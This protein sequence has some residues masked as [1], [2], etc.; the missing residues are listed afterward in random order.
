MTD[1]APL[2]GIILTP[3]DPGALV[4]VNR[5][6][7]VAIF[8]APQ[9]VD[10]ILARVAE[11]ALDFTPN[12]STKAGRA[13][14][15]SRARRVAST[16]VYLD[17]LGKA[18]VAR[19]KDLPRQID[20]G[21]KTLRD[22][23]DA[24]KD[25]VR[26]PL[27]AWEAEDQRQRNA[28]KFI[29]DRPRSMAATTSA[30]IKVEVESLEQVVTDGA[31]FGPYAEEA[32]AAK[33][34]TLEALRDLQAAALQRE[35]DARELERLRQEKAERQAEEERERLR[36]EGED[37]ARRQAEEDRLRREAQVPAP[38]A[39]PTPVPEPDAPTPAATTPVTLDQA[40]ALRRGQDPATDLEHRRAFNREALADILAAMNTEAGKPEGGNLAEA[41]LRAIVLGKVRHIA[42]TY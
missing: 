18:E 37:R 32:A 6:D 25:K 38:A 35:E 13:E 34:Q 5:P 42:I 22:G 20:A 3:E 10:A 30:Q 15:A 23:F 40:D 36:R 41:V 39:D 28:V 27:D 12:L 33:A 19:L 2:E 1:T 26:A 9:V 24:L 17:D 8:T 14:I 4:I 21:R 29:L 31:A 7:P 11:V 16:K